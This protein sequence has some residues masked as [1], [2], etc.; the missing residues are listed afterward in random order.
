V[1]QYVSNPI[2]SDSEDE[3]KIHR[4]ENRAIKKR[5][6]SSKTG[7]NSREYGQNKVSCTAPNP[8]SVPSAS[9]PGRPVPKQQFL[10]KQQLWTTIRFGGRYV[11]GDF[12]HF[13]RECPLVA[14][15]RN[16]GQQEKKQ[17]SV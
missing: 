11:C 16:S 10:Q 6:M 13:Q 9:Y 17:S 1:N 12:T 15:G 5:K 8:F 4:A 2:R 3:S 7:K 14:R